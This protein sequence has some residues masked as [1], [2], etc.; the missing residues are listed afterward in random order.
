MKL[1]PNIFHF[2]LSIIN[3]LTFWLNWVALISLVAMMLYITT[4][5]VIRLF[6]RPIIGVFETVGLLGVIL[7]FFSIPYTQV[8]K[9][10]CNIPIFV[11]K[12]P[13][14]V[15]AIIYAIIYFI[16]LVVFSVAS[17]QSFVQAK[18]QWT[19]NA[20]TETLKIALFPFEVVV[21]F[22][23]VLLS[24]VLFT[25]SLNSLTTNKEAMK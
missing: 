22:G 8:V 14:R 17:W 13:K 7:A 10:H 5:V 24:L 23:F 16:S 11:D 9:G 1:V 15:Q 12:F 3:K 25:D 20:T 2:S 6:F 4:N 21:F 18:K 19:I